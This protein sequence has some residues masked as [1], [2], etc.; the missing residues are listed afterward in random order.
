MIIDE[1][2]EYAE[3]VDPAIVR[4]LKRSKEL[5]DNS[6]FTEASLRIGRAV[7]ASLYS[8]AREV[9]V[10]LQNRSITKIFKVNKSLRDAEILIMRE[11]TPDR[12]KALSLISK[13]LSE[14]IADLTDNHT[15]REGEL[16]MIT[17][18]NEQLLRELKNVIKETDIKRRLAESET[19]LRTIQDFR[20]DAAHASSD[21]AEREFDK[22]KYE[23]LLNEAKDFLTLLFDFIVGERAK[24]SNVFEIA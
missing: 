13:S 4:E 19:F 24:K 22:E 16:S 7:E 12:V 8:V 10:E 15:L 23:V 11:R 3:A 5:A 9:S 18:P 2:I 6:F 14:A 1:L 20:N 17:R 21:G